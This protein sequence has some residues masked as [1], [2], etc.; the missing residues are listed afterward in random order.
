LIA[1]RTNDIAYFQDVIERGRARMQ[2]ATTADEF[3]QGATREAY[4][5]S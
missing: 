1:E 4:A 2:S 3:N 5:R